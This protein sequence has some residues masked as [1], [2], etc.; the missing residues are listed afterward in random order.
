MNYFSKY[1][2]GNA[3]IGFTP[4]DQL[5]SESI[6]SFTTKDTKACEGKEKSAKIYVIR[7]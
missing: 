6:S 7:G 4:G 3:G 1:L 5:I 2:T